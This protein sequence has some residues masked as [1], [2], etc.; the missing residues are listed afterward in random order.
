MDSI[1]Y[2]VESA[3]MMAPI[4]RR[5]GDF[6]HSVFFLRPNSTA[7]WPVVDSRSESL[8]PSISTG[9]VKI[10][11]TFGNEASP[12]ARLLNEKEEW[13]SNF[14]GAG[15][16]PL[17]DSLKAVVK[18]QL[19]VIFA[20]D[21]L[22]DESVDHSRVALRSVVDA[23]DEYVRMN[24][25]WSLNQML[26]FVEPSSMRKITSVAFLRTSFKH[27]EKLSNWTALYNKTLIH[28][29]ETGQDADRALRGLS[30]SRVVQI[31]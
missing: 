12:R 19:E 10:E 13:R 21:S 16:E 5:I 18:S 31:G 3:V 27:R 9:G 11:L 30:R 8:T 24:D 29:N 28:L 26:G 22:A 14:V 15:I 20:L 25:I 4:E 17:T 1:P 2:Y 7:Y 23:V 6:D